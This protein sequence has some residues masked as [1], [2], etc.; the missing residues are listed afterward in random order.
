MTTLI[1]LIALPTISQHLSDKQ[2]QSK[3]VYM[4]DSLTCLTPSKGKEIAKSLE[5]GKANKKIVDSLKK[6]IESY[7]KIAMEYNAKTWLHG[8]EIEVLNNE[9][10]QNIYKAE[11]KA[12]TL[13]NKVKKRNKWIIRLAGVN[14]SLL[15]FIYLLTTK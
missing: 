12:I 14:V 2:R 5:D 8:Q 6:D 11:S 13:N 9:C 4:I 3:G 15:G 7:K 1:T 10:S